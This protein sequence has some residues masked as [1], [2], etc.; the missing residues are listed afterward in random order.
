MQTELVRRQDRVG[1]GAEAVEG[2]EAEVEQ[3]GPADDDVEAEREQCEEDGVDGDTDDVVRAGDE[4]Y[5][6]CDGHRPRENRPPRDAFGAGEERRESPAA[7]A[8]ALIGARD[9]LVDANPR[10]VGLLL[11]GLGL[12]GVAHTF[13]MSCFP[14][15]PLGRTSRSTIRIEK[16]KTS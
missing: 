9:P 2:D 10:A 1:V 6:R 12:F 5:E 8:R 14:S 11:G 15:R 13:W 16:T 7:H 3:S 4:G